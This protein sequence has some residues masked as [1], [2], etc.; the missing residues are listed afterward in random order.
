[1]EVRTTLQPGENGTKNL[2]RKYGDRLITVRY[3]YDRKKG[4]RYK[5]VELIE[6][7]QP[8]DPTPSYKPDT[9]VA[10]RIQYH[11]AE[12]RKKV[13]NYGARWDSKNKNWWIPYHAVL[14]LK[15]EK[16]MVMD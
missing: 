13:R 1:M 2:L 3:R 5:T 14:L 8:W 12:L 10:I 11:E 7:S 9:E 6:D 15:L 4:M 16:R